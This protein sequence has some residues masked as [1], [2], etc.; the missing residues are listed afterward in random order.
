MLVV[1]MEKN[2]K[3]IEEHDS[4]S[5]T[6]TDFSNQYDH[7]IVDYGSL[8]HEI[9]NMNQELESLKE[10]HNMLAKE[11]AS[12]FAEKSNRLPDDFVPPCSKC[13]EHCNGDSNAIIDKIATT[14]ND[15]YNPSSVE[16]V[17]ITDEKCW[18]KNLLE[19]GMLKSLKGHQTLCD[20]LKKSILHKTPSKE[21]LGFERKTQC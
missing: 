13:L 3:L 18:L 2:Q 16:F 8:S 10:S 14:T 19:T 1:Q 5:S 9:I 12:L 15:N 6:I 17:A 20:V 21:G 7:H 11:K 4:F